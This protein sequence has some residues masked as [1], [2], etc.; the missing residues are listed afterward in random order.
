MSDPGEV[1]PTV[2]E[3]S[4]SWAAPCVRPRPLAGRHEADRIR[5]AKH[6]ECLGTPVH[7]VDM[8]HALCLSRQEIS[9][10]LVGGKLQPL[11]DGGPCKPP[12]LVHGEETVPL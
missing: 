8:L 3:G 7:A 4:A 5:G 10:A 12:R 1:C 11:R 6:G 9:T 2:Q